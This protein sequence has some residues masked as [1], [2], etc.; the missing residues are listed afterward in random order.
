M[1]LIGDTQAYSQGEVGYVSDIQAKEFATMDVDDFT[2]IVVEGDVMSDDLGPFPRYKE[3]MS[4]AN[5]PQYYVPG[6]HCTTLRI[7]L[8][9][10]IRLSWFRV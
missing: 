3:I 1:M 5:T 9:V 6:N 4:V 10:E 8:A 2:G 7:G